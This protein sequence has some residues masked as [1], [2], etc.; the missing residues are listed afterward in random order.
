MY[1][2]LKIYTI[3]LI[4]KSCY[5]CTYHTIHIVINK[6]S[7]FLSSNSCAAVD[8]PPPLGEAIFLSSNSC[9][10]VDPPPPLDEAIFLSSNSCAAVDPP[11]PL[12]EAIFIKS[13]NTLFL[14]T[15]SCVTQY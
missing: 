10:A 7:V 13:C 12:D 9:A 8:P 1:F 4:D 15:I 5:H 3:V 2:A 11:P 14:T 6:M